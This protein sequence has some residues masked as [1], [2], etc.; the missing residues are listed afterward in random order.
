MLDVPIQPD[1]DKFNIGL[2]LEL[3]VCPITFGAYRSRVVEIGELS[4]E[5]DDLV[6]EHLLL[7]V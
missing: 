6:K 5:I 4:L 3:T 2:D 7:N 1:Q